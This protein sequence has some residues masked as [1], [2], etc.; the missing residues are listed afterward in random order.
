MSMPG[1][2]FPSCLRPILCGL[3]LDAETIQ[4]VPPRPTH[5]QADFF[6]GPLAWQTVI[7][8]NV[9]PLDQRVPFV[10]SAPTLRVVAMPKLLAP[11]QH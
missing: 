7:H 4:S 5:A 2:D 8:W 3:H 10:L 9:L 11:H 1:V 6:G